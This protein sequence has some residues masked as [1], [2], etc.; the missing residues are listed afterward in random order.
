MTSQLPHC[1]QIIQALGPTIVSLVIGLVAVWIAFSQW[2]TAENARRQHLFDK[3]F[4]MYKATS[5]ILA[6][7]LAS[8]LF[9]RALKPNAHLE[10][11]GEISGGRFLFNKQ[12]Y[13]YMEEERGAAKKR[14][15]PSGF[16]R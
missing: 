9:D 3:R 5:S 15:R 13:S 2:R 6:Q 10:Y 7:V 16:H 1:V 11:L 14:L 8:C 4:A 12:V